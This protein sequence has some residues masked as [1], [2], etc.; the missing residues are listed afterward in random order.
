[1]AALWDA[2]Q[3]WPEANVREKL[4]FTITSLY[5]RVTVLSEFRFWGGSGNVAN[6]NVPTL[7]NEQNVFKAF[8]RKAGTI[9][10]YFRNATA[11]SGDV[12]VSVQPAQR[13][14]QL[15]DKSVDYIFTDPP[16]GANINYS[17][18]NFLWESWLGT[19]TDTEAEAI[20]NI[21]QGKGYPEYETLLKEAFAEARR[22]LKDGAWMTVVFHN[23]S[24]RAW[25]ALQDATAA[26]GF[27][28]VAAGTFD[29]KHGTF[30]MHTSDNAVGYDVILH[31]RKAPADASYAALPRTTSAT[32]SKSAAKFVKRALA[33]KP[34]YRTTF[35]HVDRASELDY[36]RLY[37]EW[38]AK[39]IGTRHVSMSFERFRAIVDDVLK[40]GG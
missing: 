19:H 18:M 38:L 3:R 5:Q 21:C 31:C 26:A 29:K 9:A 25:A 27:D 30:K 40:D 33:K 35:L 2:A 36:R 28:I 8:E 37:S 14:H 20:V 17:E 32:L 6:Y 23:S 10:L 11:R 39:S 34:T 15:P 22:V 4:V 7:M 1:M 24:Q 13:L 12:R 16:F